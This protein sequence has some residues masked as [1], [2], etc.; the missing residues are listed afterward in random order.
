MRVKLEDVCE[1]GSSNIKQSD[2]IKMSGN[3]PIYGASGLAGKVNFYHQEQPY[4]AVVKDGAGIG[5]TTLNPAK[6]SVIGTM[7]Y[8]IPKKNVLPEYLFYAVSYMHLEKYYTGATIPHIYF[9]DYKNEEFNLDNIEK[10]LEIIDVLGRCKKVIEA[11]KQELVEL[12]R[13]MKARFVEMF[14]DININNKNWEC[15][16]LGN[17]CTIV[18]GGSPRPIEKFLGGDVPW[19]KIGDATEA[20][21]IYLSSTKEHIIKEGVKNSRLVKEGS[22]IFANCGVSLGFARIITFDGCIHDGRLAMEDIDKRLDKVF[23]LQALNQ[24]TEHFRAIAPAGTQP[25]LNTAIMKAYKQVIPPIEL[26]KE[27]IRFV[28]QVNK[29]LFDGLYISQNKALCDEHMGKY[30]VIFL[31]LKGVEGLT[32]ADAKMM[33]KS[34]LSTEMDR[35]Y[36]LK[37]SEALTD[38]DKAYFVKMLTG[39]DENIN[40][41]LRKLSQLLYKHYGKKAVILIDE[42][43]VPLDKAYQNG[44][45]HEMVSL[46]RGLFG[47]ALKTNDYLQFAILTGCLRISKESIFTGLNNFKVLSIMDARFDEQFGFTDSEVEELLAAY[48]LDSHFTE[49]KEWYDGYHFGNADVYCPWD[50]I[51]YVDLLRFEP[52]AKPQDFWSNSSGNAL[53]R[54][55]ID[56]ADVQTKDEIERLIAGEYIEKELSQELT[57]DEIDKSIANLWSVL[58]TTGYLTKQ[59]VTDDGKVRLSIPNREIKNLFIKKIREW[60]SDTTA[61]DGK[62]LEQFCNAFV[63]RDTEKIEQLFGDYLWNT[64]SIRDTAVAKDKKENFYHGILLGLLGYKASWLIKS[65]TESGTGY[66]DILVEVPNNRTGIV[67]ELKYAENGDMDAACD[68]ALNQIEE[69]SYVDKLKQDGMRNFIKYGIACFKKDCKVV[70]SE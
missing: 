3:Y 17:L 37:T 40:D 19:I 42:Y 41:S 61:N 44:Y 31:T 24:M 28:H 69:K 47:Q 7:Q 27:F 43:D 50:V 67:I 55:F 23:L 26:Q 12:D 6:S 62:T 36:Y 58:F 57:Y 45:Y 46:I 13:L 20:D 34:I 22:L 1:R 4:V 16:F 53:V 60:F 5:R 66:S 25:N 38:E 68:E 63:E 48:N 39:T 11:R 54:R 52:T 15:E 21:N 51:N 32:F 59:G 9:K 65:N 2:I 70:V 18:R 33:L 30:P 49:I 29:S 35:H 14:G 56:K 8:L 10:Q 64:I